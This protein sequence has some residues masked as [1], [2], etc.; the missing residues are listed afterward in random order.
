MQTILFLILI[1]LNVLL[2]DICLTGLNL[3]PVFSTLVQFGRI[4]HDRCLK[5]C[6]LAQQILHQAKKGTC[7]MLERDPI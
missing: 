3:G 1:A 2:F 5:S 4:L 6:L 7:S